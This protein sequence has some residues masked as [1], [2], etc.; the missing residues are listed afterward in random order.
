MSNKSRREKIADIIFVSVIVIL[1]IIY[2]YFQI[3]VRKEQ[4][5]HNNEVI[6]TMEV[7]NTIVNDVDK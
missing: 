6:E 2:I 4:R 7:N 1:S 3:K 5:L